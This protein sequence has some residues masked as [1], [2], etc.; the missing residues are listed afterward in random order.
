MKIK[1]SKKTP[2][3]GVDPIG[4]RIRDIR[5]NAKL[6]Q[7]ELA[8][9]IGM[10]AAGVGA[11]ENGLYTPNYNVI[12]VLHERFG[13]TYDYIIDGVNLTN[14]NRELAEENKKLK[15]DLARLNKIIDKLTK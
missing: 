7:K 15:D 6:T 3:S 14:N 5:H 8:E 13:V 11:L 10:T 4:S 9:I 2:A 12:R 1:K